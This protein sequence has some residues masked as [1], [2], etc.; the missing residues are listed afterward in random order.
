ME[1][2]RPRHRH[3]VDPCLYTIY[4]FD[5]GLNRIVS[6]RK[7]R[8]CAT[9]EETTDCQ[10]SPLGISVPRQSCDRDFCLIATKTT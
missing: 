7:C 1:D 10:P 8:Y 2:D 3:P 6:V 4:A 5:I 9:T